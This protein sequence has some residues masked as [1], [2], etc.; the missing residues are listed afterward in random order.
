[1]QTLNVT[2]SRL[3]RSVAAAVVL[4]RYRNLSA[5]DVVEKSPGEIV[6][7]ADREAEERLTAGLDAIG[8]GARIIG[9]EACA[10][11]PTLLDGIGRGPVW[12]VDPIDGTANFAAGH[13]PFG[14]MVAFAIDGL[15]QA[16]W[17]Y[18]PVTQR[19]CHATRRRGAFINGVRLHARP[20]SRP[21][22][23]ASLATQFMPLAVR[24]DVLAQAAQAFDVVPIPRCAAE[25]YPRVALGENDIALFQR[26]LPWDHAAGALFLTEAG[27]RVSRWDGAD[28]RLGDDRTGLLAATSDRLW[29]RAA[30]Q[31]FGPS[32]ALRASLPDVPRRAAVAAFGAH[33]QAVLAPAFDRA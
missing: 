30:K 32:T 23:I 25:H 2:V 12:L 3:I 7:S 15:P 16:A 18:D 26:T 4:P 1:M 31:L 21:R 10:A 13:G 14:I 22:P 17:I 5:S 8:L 29:D 33:R 24:A 9:E 28:Y 6:T 20:V 19:M 27:G 11:D